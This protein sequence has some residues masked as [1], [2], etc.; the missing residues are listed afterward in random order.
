MPISERAK[1]VAHCS[2][3]AFAALCLM[4]PAIHFFKAGDSLSES[5]DARS[6]YLLNTPASPNGDDVMRAGD[7]P[8]RVEGPYWA[9][10][11]QSVKF[12]EIRPGAPSAGFAS[13]MGSPWMAQRTGVVGKPLSFEVQA[14]AS[15]QP[16]HSEDRTPVGKMRN[17]EL[18]R[19]TNLAPA[20]HV[21]ADA[22]GSARSP[23]QTQELPGGGL[24]VT[25]P[26]VVGD[27]QVAW[28]YPKQA[29]RAADGSWT[30]S[31][32]V[33]AAPAKEIAAYDSDKSGGSWRLMLGMLCAM[34]A[35][36]AALS[37][38]SRFSRHRRGDLSGNGEL[39]NR[40]LF[41]G[42]LVMDDDLEREVLSRMAAGAGSGGVA[43]AASVAPSRRPKI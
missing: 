35:G 30:V 36:L 3:S 1:T 28:V 15:D 33:G 18:R 22:S 32:A 17:W 39:N 5:A 31:L 8:D 19:A 29:F 38:W 12:T 43:S 41:C 2:L 20:A 21:R 37:G 7:Q 24:R 34:S 25:V 42:D 26:A 16:A 9:G 6:P 10:V 4:Q 27:A 23:I 40:G 11:R 14:L 13:G